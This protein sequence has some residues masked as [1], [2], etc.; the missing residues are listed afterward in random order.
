MELKQKPKL[1]LVTGGARSGKSRHAL[2]LAHGYERKA[3]VA[4][5]VATDEEMEE[6]IARHRRER[7]PDWQTFEEPRALVGLLEREADNFDLILIDCLSFWVSNLLWNQQDEGAAEIKI[8]ELL[9]CFKR[10]TCTLIVV[11]NEVGM[12][13]VPD[14]SVSRMFRDLVGHANQQIARLADQAV[15]MVAGL[16]LE[17]K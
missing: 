5:G 13:I 3:Y 4:T 10:R 7:G 9:V 1:I 6:R 12:G 2:G 8:S 16:P 17:L 15:F 14:N 11:S